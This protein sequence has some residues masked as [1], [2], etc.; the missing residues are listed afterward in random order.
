MAKKR[1]VQTLLAASVK[2]GREEHQRM[3]QSVDSVSVHSACY[4]KY[5]NERLASCAS[6][7]SESASEEPEE[8]EEQPQL[9]PGFDFENKCLFCGEAFCDEQNCWNIGGKNHSVKVMK[10]NGVGDEQIM[11]LNQ[12]SAQPNPLHLNF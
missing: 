5:G 4:K 3:L 8:P 2:R 7:R 9:I 11:G 12:L 10:D 1:S 6:R